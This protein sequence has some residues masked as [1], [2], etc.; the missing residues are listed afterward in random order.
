MPVRILIGVTDAAPP[1]EDDLQ[2]PIPAPQRAPGAGAIPR[3]QQ[4]RGLLG[5]AVGVLA[6]GVLIGGA[7]GAG[8]AKQPTMPSPSPSVAATYAPDPSIPPEAKNKVYSSGQAASGEYKANTITAEPALKATKTNAYTVKVETSLNTDP[9]AVARA[10]QGALDDP[11]GWA[12]FGKNNFKLVTLD[13]EGQLTFVLAS[14]KTVDALC[15]AS[16]TKGLWDCRKGNQIVLNSDRWFY[17]TPSYAS[18]GLADF[19]VYQVNHQVGFVLG[20]ATTSCKKKGAKAPVMA[21]QA[22]GLAGCL[23]N[24]WPKM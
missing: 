14:P 16:L 19:R 18:A 9:D 12:S 6:L 24:P 3:A 2:T 21:D 5:L 8:G 22:Q 10:I 7:R 17:G 1:P 23:A 4:R 20:Q 15:G 11:K 13:A